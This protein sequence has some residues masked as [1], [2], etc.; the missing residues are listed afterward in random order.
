[1]PIIQEAI[2]K[3]EVA[4][5]MRHLRIGLMALA[6]I[7]VTAL[8]NF[9]CF[10][11]MSTQEAMDSAQLARNISSGK[12]YST[13]FIRPFSMFLM[14]RHN[15]PRSPYG[16]RL[17]QLSQIQD[18][19]PDIANAPVYPCVLAGLMKVFPFRYAI[20]EKPMPFWSRDNGAF[21]RY[22][23]DFLI[24][25]FNQL[26]FF[27]LIVA[28][29]FLALRLFD[30]PTAWLSAALLFGADILWRFSMSGLSTMLLLLIFSGLVWCLVLIEETVRDGN[31]GLIPLVVLA[32][33]LGLSCGLGALTRY[34]F[35][36]M[37]VLVVIF[38]LLL[39][40]RIFLLPGAERLGHNIGVSSRPVILSVTIVVFLVLTRPWIIRN[41]HVSGTP[42]G[43]AGYFIYDGTALFP[44]NRL[45][46]SLQPELP[47]FNTLWLTVLTQKLLS[48]VRQIVENDL[49]RLGGGFIGLFFFVGLLVPVTN[50]GASRLRYFLLG[51]LVILLIT[52][53]LGRTHLS[54]DSPGINIENLL[55]LLAPFVIVFGVQ[56][57]W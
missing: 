38:L 27:G 23:P 19:H 17:S 18:R 25:A 55:V 30:K 4:G 45:E 53:A 36:W 32:L 28:I 46:R 2:H 35:G 56:F 10:K 44:E 57:F 5:G 15:E 7:G 22:Q 9:R 47:H 26:L 20:P 31:R 39:P 14:R 49:L 34:S 3:I 21:W 13:Y 40:P 33:G 43:T 11:N 42:F 48:N 6:V 8:Y 12:G 52:Q 1:M 50:P 16:T 24:A 37:I 51:S 29:F 54:D 41:F